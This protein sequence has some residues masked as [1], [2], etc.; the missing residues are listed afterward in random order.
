MLSG[1]GG[2]FDQRIV[3]QFGKYAHLTPD[4]NPTRRRRRVSLQYNRDLL[5]CRIRPSLFS[6][7]RIALYLP[8]I[9]LLLSSLKLTDTYQDQDRDTTKFLDGPVLDV[10]VGQST[11]TA[12]IVAGSSN[13]SRSFINTCRVYVLR[14]LP[15]STFR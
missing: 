13:R 9:S 15:S 11:L 2:C 14:P 3:A 6:G 1:R 12:N 10:G 4:D 7:I 8:R 5:I